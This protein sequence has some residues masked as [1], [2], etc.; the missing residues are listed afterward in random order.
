MTKI[1]MF[2]SIFLLCFSASL[3]AQNKS[4]VIYSNRLTHDLISADI[5]DGDTI[6]SYTVTTHKAWT[7]KPHTKIVCKGSYG[8]LLLF[9]ADLNDF[10]QANK[11]RLG[12]TSSV[13]GIPVAVIRKHGKRCISIGFG[14][15]ENFTSARSINRALNALV[16]WKKAAEMGIEMR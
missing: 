11:S 1:V 13:N 16:T 15:D 8:E 14:T 10:A 2:W 5:F 6:Y 12:Q 4:E 7:G 3:Q 9:L